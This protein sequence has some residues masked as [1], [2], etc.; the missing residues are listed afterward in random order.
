LIL[1]KSPFTNKIKEENLKRQQRIEDEEEFNVNV[2]A[3]N[4]VYGVHVIFI[5][6]SSP[7][8]SEHPSM[9]T[10]RRRPTTG[11]FLTSEEITQ[12]I[13]KTIQER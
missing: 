12:K 6:P 13:H 2:D 10:T 3:C 1:S 8:T 9:R 7:G 4:M 5:L 11:I